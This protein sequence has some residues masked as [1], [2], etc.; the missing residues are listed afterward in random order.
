MTTT[1]PGVPSSLPYKQSTAVQTR[2]VPWSAPLTHLPTGGAGHRSD[3]AFGVLRH[4]VQPAVELA[5][6]LA[7]V[8]SRRMRH[9]VQVQLVCPRREE[10]MERGTVRVGGC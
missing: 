3:A 6:R 7:L 5:A 4:G 10:M 2:A 9:H 8:A 1:V